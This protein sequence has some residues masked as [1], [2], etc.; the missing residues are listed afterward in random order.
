MK[1]KAF[2]RLLN[3]EK[4][5]TNVKLYVEED[6]GVSLYGIKGV[7]KTALNFEYGGGIEICIEDID[8]WI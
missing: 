4:Q 1:A 7:S 3:G 8:K 2:L 6:N 5:E